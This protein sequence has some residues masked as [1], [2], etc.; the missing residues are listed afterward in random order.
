MNRISIAI[1]LALLAALPAASFAADDLGELV[2][3]TVEAYGGE[4][5]LRK[6][7][8]VRQTGRLTATMRGPKEG[9]LTRAYQRPDKLRV[10]VALAGE[11]GEIRVLDGARGWRQGKEATGMALDAMVMQAARLGLP[12]SLLDRKADLKDLGMVSR[13]GMELQ[14]LELPLRDGMVMTVEIDPATG[15]IR[16]SAARSPRKGGMHGGGSVEFATG[17]DDFREAAGVLFAFKETNFA[18]GQ[19]TG[20][21]FI[22]KIEVMDALPETTFKP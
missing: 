5:A 11:A 13:V 17:Y 19:H 3:K 18:M 1:V 22:E 15:R 21:T 4:E 20:D 14:A 6:A 7:V 10:E 12:L 8:A 2:N 16:R 9:T